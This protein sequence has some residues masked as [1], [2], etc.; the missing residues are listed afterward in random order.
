MNVEVT[1]LPESLVALKI[2]LTPEDVELALA[3]TYKDLVQRVTI[4]GFRKGK[5]PRPVLERL[6]GKETFLHEATDQAVRWGYRKAIEVENL[7]PIDEAEIDTSD[8][9]EHVEPGQPFH[10]EATVAIK[11]VV[12][13]PE[14]KSLRVERV[15]VD[16]TG[17]DV[18]NLLGEIRA[19][20]TTLEPTIR[21]A[22]IG[23]VVTMHIN[24]KVDGAEIIDQEN[25]DFEVRD[26]GEQGPDSVLPGLS[27]ELVDVNRGD[28]KEIALQ[29]PKNYPTEDLAG[30]SMFLRILVKEIKRKVLPDLDDELARSVSEYQTLDELKVALRSNLEQE[31]RIEADEKMVSDAVDSV[32]S[33]T[34][35]E[36][37]NILI[38]EELDRM[39]QEMR[40]TLDRAHLSWETFLETTGTTVEATR[41]EMREAA[42]RNVKTSL[43]VG[44]VADAEGID[45]TN[46]ELSTALEELF[47]TANFS[48]TER[49]R[50]RTST[51]VRA[52]MRGRL[53]RQRA[54]QRLVETMTGE[55]VGAEA[56]EAM[57][58]LTVEASQ[59]IE[60]TLAVEVLG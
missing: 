2:E 52:N 42:T 30:K 45:V 46:R 37:P 20:H 25:S 13:L 29:L 11:P 19:R 24:A 15:Q 3:R 44:A 6:V 56:T 60:E 36:I 43:V 55:E 53:R 50:L 40:N 47:R 48:E 10:F 33:R 18:D 21:A 28:I 1:R 26:E 39:I 31:R 38:D 23:D 41:A 57:A 27:A 5:A 49:R 12:Q 9:N 4:P 14:Y 51:G 35:V 34:F 54:I 17:S 8:D 58:G 22:Q 59:D 32:S 7:T 16:I